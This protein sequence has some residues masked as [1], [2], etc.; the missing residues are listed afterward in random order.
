MK[1]IVSL[2]CTLLY[3]CGSILSEQK[4]IL[5]EASNPLSIE[6]ENETLV[7]QIA[8]LQK[9]LPNIPGYRL[10]VMDAGT[11]E[12]LLS[13]ETEGE[14]MFQSDFRPNERKEFLISEAPSSEK[15]A[16]QSLVDGRFVLPR[17][18][19]AWENDRI[20]FRMYGPALAAEVNNGIDV[21]T[22]RVRRLIVK[23][24]YQASE[25]SGKDTYHQDHGEGADF[26]SVGSTLGAGG[27]G[28]WFQGK[29]YQPGVFSLQRTIA[30]GPLRV[31][32]EL[33][34]DR[35]SIDGRRCKEVKRISLDAGQNLNKIEVTFTGLPATDTLSVACGLAKRKGTTFGRDE[36]ACWISLWGQTND[37]PVNGYLGTGIVL[38]PQQ[39]AGFVEDGGQYM[40]L[41][42]AVAGNRF[43]YYAGAGWTRSGD[44]T[45]VEDWNGYLDQF[46]TRL[47][48]PIRITLRLRQD[49]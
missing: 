34:Y 37:D 9:L 48:H 2:T 41:G 47:R 45:S 21:W 40:I 19:Y 16:P 8:E 35:W 15:N 31:V 42:K 23:K 3:F 26:F 36:N 6:R 46:A 22:K 32:F 20:A 43:S 33:T 29:L 27:S 11:R 39:C 25:E 28:I 5:V 12:E 4:A 13:Q 49:K 38:G 30:N 17:E 44:F 14:F 7:I 24:W 10:V 18:D 1:R